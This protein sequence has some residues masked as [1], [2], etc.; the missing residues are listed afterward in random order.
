MLSGKEVGNEQ[1]KIDAVALLLE[2]KTIK[3]HPIGTSMW[4]LF[5]REIDAAIVA[6]LNGKK[7]KR[8]D[9]C[10]Y[11]DKILVLHRLCKVNN[12]RYFFVGDH[13]TIVEEGIDEKQIYGV[14][15][16]FVRNGRTHSTQNIFYR[17]YSSVWLL[18]RPARKKIISAGS[19]F[20]KIIK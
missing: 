1:K 7:P 9:V 8:G 4:P 13:Q 19:F 20:L 12:K 14:M 15:V 11:R 6:P 16:A 18:L 5:I 2:G 3:F 10:L 17:I